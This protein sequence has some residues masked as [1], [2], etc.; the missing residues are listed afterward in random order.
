[1]SILVTGG[2][3]IARLDDVRFLANAS[4][5]RFSAS[6]TEACL[7]RG[8]RVWHLH[9]PGA[10]LPLLR[11]ARLDREL[12]RADL[13]ELHGRLDGAFKGWKEH[14]PRLRLVQAGQGTVQ[15][16]ADG[17]RAILEQEPIE[18][19]FL[20]MAVSDYAPEATPGKI[21]STLEELTVRL[22][23]TPKVIQR[24]KEWAPEVFLVGFKL[25]SGVSESEL[26]A[27][28]VAS[29]IRSRADLVVANDLSQYRSSGHVIHVVRPPDPTPLCTLG[30][31]GD[32]ARE[33]VEVVLELARRR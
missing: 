15:E 16:Y 28:A 21:S 24:V 8:E 13:E 4:T 11:W 5:G 7:R 31:D 29:G 17:L 12:E 22:R 32:P 3:T 14:A 10:E 18:V 26:V 25:L 1:M 2:G 6:I 33:L 20:A 30:R 27:A 23:P 19:A 9:A